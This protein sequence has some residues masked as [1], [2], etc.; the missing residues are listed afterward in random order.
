M[1]FYDLT[2]YPLYRFYQ[3]GC[4]YQEYHKAKKSSLGAAYSAKM[5]LKAARARGHKN[6][7]GV[8]SVPFEMAKKTQRVARKVLK[9]KGDAKDLTLSKRQIRK[10]QTAHI[11][12][13]SLAGRIGRS[14]PSTRSSE[15][16]SKR[17]H[18]EGMD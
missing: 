17:K 14:G 6:L 2:G 12:A 16:G 9:T 8:R 11:G 3:S 1:I 13:K 18:H 15:P 4:G 10:R 7:Q 5:A